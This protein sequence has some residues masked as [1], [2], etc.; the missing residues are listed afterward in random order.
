MI[1]RV[2][3]AAAFVAAVASPCTALAQN[4]SAQAPETVAEALRQAG[5][6]AQMDT[7]DVGDPMI[8]STSSGTEFLILFYG[9]TDNADCRTVQ[10]YV[11]YRDPPNA[12]LEAMNIWNTQNRFGRGYVT[13]EGSARVEMDLDLDDGGMSSELFTDNLELWVGTMARFE[14]FIDH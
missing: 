11:G 5:Y 13:D 7:D 8:R 12:S 9:C 6:R 10:F 2:L 3:A 14:E 4:V 1:G